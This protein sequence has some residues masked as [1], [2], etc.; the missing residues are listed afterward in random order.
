VNSFIARKG[1]WERE[2]RGME[3]GGLRGDT[4][5]N[6]EEDISSHFKNFHRIV[7]EQT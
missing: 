6:D 1:H 4:P 3:M 7:A 5:K 2:I